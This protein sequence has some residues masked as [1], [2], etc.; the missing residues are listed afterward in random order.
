[1][2]L[3]HA[4]LVSLSE[5]ESTGYD[6][7]RRFDRSIGRFWT[8]THQQVYKVLAR[9]ER[10]GWVASTVVAQDGRPDKKVYG[11]TD[12]GRAELS[13]WIGEPAEPEPT[14][15]DLAVKIRGASQG[16]LGAVLAEVRRHRELHVERL[17]SYLANEKREFPDPSALAGR[18][19][20]QWLVLRGGIGLE[21]GL[22]DWYD[23]V[24]AALEPQQ[25]QQPHNHR[26]GQR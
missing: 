17:E 14:R 21:R 3:E 4:I 20:H 12:A 26:T 1:M 19:L 13:A 7:A 8:A 18:E 9:M 25:L 2:A 5:R 11:L 15:S 10:D 23:E 24:L 6:L 16:D 22:V